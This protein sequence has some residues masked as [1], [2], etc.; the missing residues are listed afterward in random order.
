MFLFCITLRLTSFH[1]IFLVSF[2]FVGVVAEEIEGVPR[3]SARRRN[4]LL[5]LGFLV[6]GKVG[7][8][9]GGLPLLKNSPEQPGRH[10]DGE[11]GRGLGFGR[12]D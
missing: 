9:S 8:L 5:M 6:G 7:I 4:L 1:F 3:G 2:S 12:R 11:L 10:A